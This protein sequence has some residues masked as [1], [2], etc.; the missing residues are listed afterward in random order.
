M[1]NLDASLRNA[2]W[3]KQS[4]DF[5]MSKAEFLDY[6]SRT[7]RTLDQFKTL[8]V[9]TANRDYWD[10]LLGSESASEGRLE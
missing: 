3:T 6:L 1:V 10:K 8:P 5:H 2:D 7:G 4:P 9:Y